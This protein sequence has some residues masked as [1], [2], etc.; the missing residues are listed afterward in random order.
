MRDVMAAA[1]KPGLDMD[2]LL[3]ARTG[4]EQLDALFAKVTLGVLLASVSATLEA[5]ILHRL[6]YL[7]NAAG[8]PW[9]CFIYLSAAAHIGLNSAFQ[10]VQP[11]GERWRAWARAFAAI[12]FAEGLGWGWAPLQ[13]ISSG[14]TDIMLLTLLMT[15]GIVA[16]SVPVFGVYLPAFFAL[17]TAALLPYIFFSAF[18]SDPIISTSCV[19]AAFFAVAM[20]ALAL[21]ANQGFIREISLRIRSEG[22]A[23]DL[24]RQKEIAEQASLA[25]STFLAAA[26]HDLRQPVHALGLYVGA[27][28]GLALPP[29]A[30]HIV[31]RIESSVGAM[32]SLFS[33]LLDISRLDAG[34]VEVRRRRFAINP[35]L[36]RI[37]ADHAPEARLKGIELT[38]IPC[39][40]IADSDPVLLERI[41]RN[42][43]SNAARYTDSGRILVGCRRRG[44]SLA[45][46]VWDTGRG[47][48]LDK[49][50]RVF[51]E[52][53]QLGNPERD[54]AKGLG[55]GL[56]IVRRLTDLLDSKLTLRSRP[57]KGSCFE[58]E[59]PLAPPG[60]RESAAETASAD[61]IASTGLLAVIDDEAAIREGMFN[62]CQSWGYEVLT[63]ASG[64]EMLARL[65]PRHDRPTLILCDYRLRDGETGIEVVERLRSEYNDNIPAI[66][67]TGDTAPDRLAEARARGLL[68][69]HKPVPNGALR[70]A[71]GNMIASGVKQAEPAEIK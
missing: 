34:V 54:R 48:P 55:L 24:H 19:L 39:S 59:I 62:L 3:T 32:D 67:I 66:L 44:L 27:L 69:L 63:A 28:R 5:V 53:Y 68:L 38:A 1:Q 46:Q 17:M 25:K 18:S 22:L 12:S 6:G 43:V 56:A 16:G 70:A 50:T 65:A 11:K 2:A 9:L 45:L 58:I 7:G 52:Y 42:L 21:A 15:G 49:Q 60:A 14:R 57:G 4:R 33:A 8:L 36:E 29:E 26:S 20:S 61:T 10:K 37:C 64:D 23:R 40:A 51:Q 41:L 13:L 47:I 71:I 35:F 31:E 30:T